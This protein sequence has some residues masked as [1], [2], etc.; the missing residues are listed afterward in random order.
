MRQ[1]TLPLRGGESAVIEGAVGV[2]GPLKGL[3]GIAHRDRGLATMRQEAKGRSTRT[4]ARLRWGLLFVLL[5]VAWSAILRW[6]LGPLHVQGIGQPLI[7]YLNG[8]DH[9]LQAPG[10]V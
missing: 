7:G 4:A 9:L 10:A 2:W 6:A 1:R 8:L 3:P 5:F